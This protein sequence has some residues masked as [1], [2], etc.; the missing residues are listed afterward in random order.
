M[1]LGRLGAYVQL[2]RPGNAAM[3]ALGGAT[4]LVLAGGDLGELDLVAAATLP[5][6]FI[7]AFGN[8]VN[9]LRDVGLDRQAHPDRPLPS[10]RVRRLE[11]WT[12]AGLL[13]LAGLAWTQDAGFPAFAL[14]GLNALLLGVYEARLK[15]AGLPGNLLVG[16]L[17][18]STFV[19]GGVVAT[20]GL[21][22]EPMLALLAGVAAL[23]NV[24]RELLK[25]VEDQEADRGH[26][27]TFPLRFGP[28]AARLLA[29][30]LVNAAVLATL[31]AFVNV[32]AGWWMPW[33]IVLALADALFLVGACLAWMDVG[34]AQRLLKLAMLVA[35]GAFLA[36]PLV[37]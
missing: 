28:G 32:P 25:D 8:V 18:G 15:A 27:R 1:A 21:P 23:S 31:A 4:G 16:L 37:P 3:A 26:R 2:L 9:D 13:L 22:R 7:A 33:L 35:L 11:A 17:V 20:G 34:T 14:A 24:G 30:G 29:L 12:L 6:L 10:G 5:P 36:G 19:Y